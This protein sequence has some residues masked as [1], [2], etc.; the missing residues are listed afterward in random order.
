[1]FSTLRA[2]DPELA[3]LV[4]AGRPLFP[5]ILDRRSGEAAFLLLDRGYAK[6][7]IESTPGGHHP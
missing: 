1:M 3:V 2:E 6:F 4:Q 7:Q 5:G